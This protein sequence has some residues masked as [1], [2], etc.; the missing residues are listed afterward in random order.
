MLTRTNSVL[1]SIVNFWQG[2]GN[3]AGESLGGLRRLPYN[4]INA[5]FAQAVIGKRNTTRLATSSTQ[6]LRPTRHSDSE[7]HKTG[8]LGN[9]P[10]PYSF[11]FLTCMSPGISQ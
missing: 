2:G 8:T 10:T 7:N 5:D 3:I 4:Y 9:C 1:P 6:G 11:V